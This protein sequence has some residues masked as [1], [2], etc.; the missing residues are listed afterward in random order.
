MM[1]VAL[2]LVGLGLVALR[3]GNVRR[4]RRV[5]LRIDVGGRNTR[6]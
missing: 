1:L 3:F 2:T 6:A 5:L 4:R